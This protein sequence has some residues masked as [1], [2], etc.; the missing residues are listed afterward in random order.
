MASAASRA[1]FGNLVLDWIDHD[2]DPRLIVGED[3]RLIW[4]NMEA[5]KLL[6]SSSIFVAKRGRLNVRDKSAMPGFVQ[7]IEGA[8]AEGSVSAFPANEAAPELILEARDLSDPR[9]RRAI[10]IRVR[11]LSLDKVARRHSH[12]KS[13]F[14]LTEAEF[15]V[16]VSLISGM[17]ASEIGKN[18]HSSVE[19]VRSQIRH[20]YRKIHVS[21]R[22]QLFHRVHSLSL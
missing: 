4:C 2:S 8:S 6:A 11:E 9:G 10:G 19:T 3:L 5:R 18:R 17:T 21:S 22:E 7:L 14:Y 1:S 13:M 16:F 20:I 15:S 12:L